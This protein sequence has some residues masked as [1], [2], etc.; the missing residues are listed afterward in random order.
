MQTNSTTNI[1]TQKRLDIICY[2]TKIVSTQINGTYKNVMYYCN[3]KYWTKLMVEF[4]QGKYH[5]MGKRYKR[6]HYLSKK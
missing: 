2:G 6:L 4:F 1:I 3:G 5:A